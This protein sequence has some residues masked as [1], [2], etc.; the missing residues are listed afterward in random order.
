MRGVALMVAAALGF[1]VMNALVKRA[2]ADG[3]PFFEVASVRAITGALMVVAWARAR[4]TSL[5]VKNRRAMI[6]RTVAGTAAMSCTFY[7]LAHLPL[8]EGTALFNL[9]P[10]FVAA[11]GWIT[12]RERVSAR[13]LV[14]LCAAFVGVLV[15]LHP[16][17]ELAAGGLIA[18]AAS[19][20]AAV[21]MVSLRRLGATETPEAVVLH[22]SLW[23]GVATGVAALPHLVVPSW[24]DL[25]IMAG[26]GVAATVSQLWMTRAYALDR[27]ARVGG[28]NYL[29]IVGSAAIG[30][31]LFDET[32]TLSTAIGVAIIVASGCLL[33][34]DAYRE[35]SVK[36]SRATAR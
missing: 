8:A 11:I 15:V 12:L 4:G 19:V 28:G 26:A 30:I 10:L 29:T 27:A 35:G 23:A 32:L 18:V 34:L 36:P 9:T 1:S 21:A 6:M 2:T 14:S 5:A 20:F 7:A 33:A 31:V 24:L 3:I 13:V 16:S 22:F 17:A 25:A